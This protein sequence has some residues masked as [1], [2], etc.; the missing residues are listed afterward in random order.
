MKPKPQGMEALT[1]RRAVVADTDKVRYRV[2][3]SPTEFIAVIA[4]SAL[5]AVK[6]SGIGKPHKIVRDLPTEGI[7][8]EAR[9]MAAQSASAA[10]VSLRAAQSEKSARLVAELAPQDP[11]AKQ[12]TFRPMHLSDLQRGGAVRARILPPE[13]LT[14]IIEQ[15]SKAT[16]P[17]PPAHE[18]VAPVLPPAVVAPAAPAVA[19]ATTEE[20]VMQMAQEM[21]PSAPLEHDPNRVLSP[22]E[23]EKLL[24]G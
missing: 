1:I 5:M 12:A 17:A 11:M 13:M 7:A 10:R 2:Y 3:S 14:E 19:E 24:H 18:P 15:H 6:V 9:K 8:I 20:R 16:M 4:E 23:V 21:L 22:E